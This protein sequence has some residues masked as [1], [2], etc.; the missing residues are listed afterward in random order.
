M[1]EEPQWAEPKEH[2]KCKALE[3]GMDSVVFK[4]RLEHRDQR[5]MVD[6]AGG[7]VGPRS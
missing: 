4:K 5:S 3:V 7:L 1:T 2:S 6:E